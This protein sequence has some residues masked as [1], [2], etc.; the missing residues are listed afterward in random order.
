MF[1]AYN[2][3]DTAMRPPITPL[4]VGHKWNFGRYLG[5]GAQGQAMLWNLLD[6]NQRIVDQIVLKNM[7]NIQDSWVLKEGPEQGN[8]FEVYLQQKLAPSGSEPQ[9][10][11]TVPVTAAGRLP[12]PKPACRI[13]MPYYGF[14]DLLNLGKAQDDPLPE[15]FI[16]FLLYRLANAAILMD[17]RFRTPDNPEAAV[18][19]L[20]LKP[21]N[22]FLDLP[23]S[24]GT[25]VDFF[26]YPPAFI[27]DF[28]LSRITARGS[29]N[30]KELVGSG[31]N[32][33]IPPEIQKRL[34]DY[35]KAALDIPASSKTN[36]WQIGHVVLMAMQANLAKT[37][38][39][40]VQWEKNLT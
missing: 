9:E 6:E 32:G 34:G 39:E 4:P 36:I 29:S 14:G 31:T 21:Q 3:N 30:N 33:W 38:W 27:G 11:F 35:N 12:G 16:W 40:Q 19:H 8:L 7:K 26:A 1:A 22:I 15:P 20:D 23:G 17:E 37:A 13:Y 24:L 2:A 5:G 10:I 25:N 28:G 18:V